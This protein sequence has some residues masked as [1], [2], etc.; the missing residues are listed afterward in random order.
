MPG[1]SV[2]LEAVSG[3][4]FSDPVARPEP[5]SGCAPCR[6]SSLPNS[7]TA[8]PHDSVFTLPFS[9]FPFALHR[10]M[11][12]FNLSRHPNGMDLAWTR[13]NGPARPS[14]VELGRKGHDSKT[15]PSRPHKARFPWPLLGDG[16]ASVTARRKP[17]ADPRWGIS[18][19]IGGPRRVIMVVRYLFPAVPR[20]SSKPPPRPRQLVKI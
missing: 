7:S 8:S 4:S 19:P 17:Q 10:K 18:P 14:P 9:P 20:T 1:S 5:G 3:A 12:S 11:H 6:T 2:E 16:T 15:L 13:I